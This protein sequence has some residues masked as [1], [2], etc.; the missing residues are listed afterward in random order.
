M[1]ATVRLADG[2]TATVSLGV[3][4]SSDPDLLLSCQVSAWQDP[5]DVRYEPDPDLSA[6]MRAA[7][8]LGGVV[9]GVTETAEPGD[10]V[11]GP[12]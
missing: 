11:Y 2:R 8:A 5:S 12:S 10:V 3:W 1:S 4:S 6:A 9:V 7:E